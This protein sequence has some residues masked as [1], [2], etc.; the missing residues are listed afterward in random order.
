MKSSQIIIREVQI[1]EDYQAIV[2][3]WRSVGPGIHLG[4]SDSLDEIKKKQLRDPD[5]FLIAVGEGNV[6]GTV[7]GGFDGRR[8]IVYH[9]AV[10]ETYRK[11]GIGKSLMAELETRLRNKGCIRSY[12]LVTSDSPENVD[13]YINQGWNKMDLFIMAKDIK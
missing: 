11:Q 1:P 4:P 10:S 8:G 6:I 2:E 13:Y 7:L 12:L 9:L 3:L 5:L